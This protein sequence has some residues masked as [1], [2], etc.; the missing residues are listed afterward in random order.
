MD[1]A[2]A[3][4]YM[5]IA[6][7][8][9]MAIVLGLSISYA[10]VAVYGHPGVACLLVFLGHMQILLLPGFQG[11]PIGV[12]VEFLDLIT[13]LLAITGLLRVGN[14]A[15][16]A[17]IPTAYW[18]AAAVM[19]LSFVLG[20][21]KYKTTAGVAFRPYFHMM[22][23]ALY[24]STVPFDQRMQ[25]LF[26]RTCGWLAAVLALLC[27]LRWAGLMD[28]FDDAA[29]GQ[30]GNL[31]RIRVINSVQSLLLMQF[32]LMAIVG[33]RLVFSPA[34]TRAVAVVLLS[35][36][37]ALQHRSVWVA[38]LAA[39]AAIT[40]TGARRNFGAVVLGGAIMAGA[41]ALFNVLDIG[42]SLLGEISRSAQRAVEGAD[43]TQA[44]LDTWMFA[45]NKWFDGG[46]SAWLFGMPFGT[47]LDRVVVNS[48]GDHQ[49]VSFQTHSFY[50]GAIF[51]LGLV[52]FL[53]YLAFFA[54][55]ARRLLDSARAGSEGPWPSILFV[56]VVSQLVYY[57]TY[58]LSY[59]NGLLFG[60][61]AAVAFKR[62]QAQTRAAAILAERNAVSALQRQTSP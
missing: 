15:S 9:V 6:I 29:A 7:P 40:L 44:R 47:D 48:Q 21:V 16:A 56:L 8:Y 27:V 13:V 51:N 26:L 46:P 22:A 45:L 31:E 57:L 25:R 49:K 37:L 5:L 18:V 30:F 39:V 50:V 3:L 53:G 55:T 62:H 54:A 58:G 34:F 11:I 10:C 38:G 2:E 17:E 12:T 52:G 1:F 41:A 14:R 4:Q 20:T 33:Q 28:N 24:F 36:T 60:V 35:V 59:E 61:C 19:L 42:G 23:V 43:S 32:A